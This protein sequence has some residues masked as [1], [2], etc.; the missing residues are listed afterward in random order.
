[1]RSD[2]N[3]SSDELIQKMSSLSRDGENFATATVVSVK[4]STT[5]RVGFKILI[6]KDGSILLGNLGGGCSESVVVGVNEF[7]EPDEIGTIPL[8]RIDERVEREQVARTSAFRAAR[9]AAKVQRR[10]E[11]VKKAASGRENLMPH[12]VDAVDDGATLGEICDVLRGVFG[13]Y[14]A[15]E[16][17][18]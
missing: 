9:D 17:V 11:D 16:I 2:K 5:G 12:F 3:L 13:V 4:G 7:V 8:Q 10:L 18:A 14:R 15:K 6:G 1:M